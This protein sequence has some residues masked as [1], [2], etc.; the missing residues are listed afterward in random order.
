[1]R[2]LFLAVCLMFSGVSAFSQIAVKGETVWTM[3]G[4]PIKDGVVL[5]NR[6]KIEAVGTAASIQIPANYKVVSARSSLRD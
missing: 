6:G 3:S 5:I 2:I 1:M 4:D